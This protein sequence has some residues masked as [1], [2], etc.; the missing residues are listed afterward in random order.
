MKKAPVQIAYP[1]AFTAFW[2]AAASTR[3]KGLKSDAFRAWAKQGKPPADRLT[4]KWGEYLRSLGE[5]F[6]KDICRW[7]AARGWEETYEAPRA[8]PALA[9]AP[10]DANCA[11]WHQ[12]GKNTNRAHPRGEQRGCPEC[13]GV[14]LRKWQAEGRKGEPAQARDALGMVLKKAGNGS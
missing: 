1:E 4:A 3:S 12:G 6:P 11:G 13:K 7:I 9:Q 2:D 5:T 8:R 10:R 14:A